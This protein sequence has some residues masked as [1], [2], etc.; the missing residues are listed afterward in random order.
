MVFVP[1]CLPVGHDC[2]PCKKMAELIDTPDPV[3]HVL[4]PDA[5]GL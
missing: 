2:K 4:D 3:N 1:V 5:H